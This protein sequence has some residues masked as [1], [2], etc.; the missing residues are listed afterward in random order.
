MLQTFEC[1]MTDTDDDSTTVVMIEAAC[2][3]DAVT[4]AEIITQ[5][6]RLWAGWVPFVTSVL[7]E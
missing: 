7:P 6:D 2:H 4:T 5:P 1:I 3:S